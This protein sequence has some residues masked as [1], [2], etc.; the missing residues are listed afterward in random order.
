MATTMAISRRGVSCPSTPHI[1]PNLYHRHYSIRIRISHI[2]LGLAL[3][4]ASSQHAVVQAACPALSFQF[5]IA[6]QEFRANDTI[7]VSYR[8][9]SETQ[10]MNLMCTTGATQGQSSQNRQVVQK[11]APAFNNTVDMQ[12]PEN[13]IG[14]NCW[15]VLLPSNQPDCN[16]A[17]AKLRS[18]LFKVVASGPSPSTVGLRSDAS[19]AITSPSPS[20]TQ[21]T[22]EKISVPVQIGI[23]VGVSVVVGLLVGGLVVW[24]YLRKQARNADNP[25]GHDSRWWSFGFPKIVWQRPNRTEKRGSEGPRPLLNRKN[26]SRTDSANF[27]DSTTMRPS[28]ASNFSYSPPPQ[29]PI[30]QD[31]SFYVGN[32]ENLPGFYG[33]A[34]RSG[35][36]HESLYGPSQYDPDANQPYQHGPYHTF[37]DPPKGDYASYIGDEEVGKSTSYR[38]RAAVTPIE[39]YPP[40]KDIGDSAPAATFQPSAARPP[41][42]LREP[43]AELPGKESYL[44]YGQQ[45]ELPTQHR[46]QPYMPGGSTAAVAGVAGPGPTAAAAMAA[47]REAQEQKFLLQDV[48]LMG[49]KKKREPRPPD[50]KNPDEYL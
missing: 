5:P 16:L 50:P 46:P 4:L 11:A 26:S 20:P 30:P 24:C 14:E 45:F 23:G 33:S 49:L 18:P 8:S 42:L 39:Y 3:L 15:F 21:A 9:K 13:A 6:D 10:M 28:A 22:E 19:N 48:E 35:T 37:S 38:G 31:D 47:R 17:D 32:S 1:I 44:G 29:G 27:S 34:R 43:D 36:K 2:I 41:S 40:E 12:L 25:G 7:I